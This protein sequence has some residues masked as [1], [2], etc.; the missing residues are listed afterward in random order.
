IFGFFLYIYASTRGF[1]GSEHS[2]PT[3]RS[4]DLDEVPHRALHDSKLIYDLS[5]K[6]NKFLKG[7]NQ[8]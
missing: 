8:K 2:F 3:G 6:M 5:T 1:S 4:S 7:I